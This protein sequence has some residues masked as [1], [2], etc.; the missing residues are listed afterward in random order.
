MMMAGFSMAVTAQEYIIYGKVLDE[1]RHYAISDV[2]ISIRGTNLGCTTNKNGEF[3]FTTQSLPVFMVI[4]NLG[5]ES[6]QIRL[7][8]F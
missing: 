2:N 1:E 4:S 5:Y 7:E 6:R 8:K 3:S